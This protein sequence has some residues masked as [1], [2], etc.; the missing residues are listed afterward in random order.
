MSDASS[1]GKIQP[2]QSEQNLRRRNGPRLYDKRSIEKGR[3][4]EIFAVG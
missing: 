3:R 2:V 1:E 4:F